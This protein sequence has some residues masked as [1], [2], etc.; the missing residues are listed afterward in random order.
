MQE[1]VLDVDL[2]IAGEVVVQSDHQG[3]GL[4]RDRGHVEVRVDDRPPHDRDVGVAGEDVPD[5]VPEGDAVHG[6]LEIG[7]AVEEPPDDR[8]GEFTRAE[9]TCPDPQHRPPRC[10]LAHRVARQ[11]GGRHDETRVLDEFHACVRQLDA[12]GAPVEERHAHLVLELP[13]GPRHGRLSDVERVGGPAEPAFVDDREE[14]PQ[15]TEIHDDSRSGVQRECN[16][17]HTS[18]SL[19]SWI[20]T[21]GATWSRIG[22]G[23][24]PRSDRSA[25][26]TVE[27]VGR[28]TTSRGGSP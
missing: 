20:P 3:S 1:D 10:V 11:V 23:P 6:H 13:Q 18:A 21:A 16:P 15:V 8:V 7:V 24:V 25:C 12:A 9:R 4:G 19:A 28:R 27:A 22:A 5:L 2:L 26:G 14:E 17:D